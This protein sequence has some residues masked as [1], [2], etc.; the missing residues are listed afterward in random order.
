MCEELPVEICSFAIS[1]FGNRCLLETTTRPYASSSEE[2]LQCRTSPV[3]VL[4]VNDDNLR[5]YIESDD[6]IRSCGLDRNSIGI[7][8]D[9]LLD[10]FS[11]SKICSSACSDNCPN[12]LDLYHNLAMAEGNYN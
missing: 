4:T 8:S 6:C 12:I 10:P 2:F 5:E 7:S 9:A 3:Q 1:S 11:V